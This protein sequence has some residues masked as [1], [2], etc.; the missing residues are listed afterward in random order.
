[1]VTHHRELKS[2]VTNHR[3]LKM[4][5]QK[6]QKLLK[7]LRPFVWKQVLV[8]YNW[9]IY[10]DLW[11]IDSSIPKIIVESSSSA[12]SILNHTNIYPKFIQTP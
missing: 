6:S 9:G 5:N 10:Y 2:L 3:V 1:M 4:A 7:H 12:S 8:C 11:C